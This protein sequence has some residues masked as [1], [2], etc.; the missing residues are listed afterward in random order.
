M[1]VRVAVFEEGRGITIVKSLARI[2]EF[3]ITKAIICTV[4]WLTANA[5][6]KKKDIFHFE[7]LCI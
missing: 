1:M 4:V 7:V 6:L 3:K 5:L 2:S